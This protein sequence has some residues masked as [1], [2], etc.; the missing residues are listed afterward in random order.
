MA[1]NVLLPQWGMNMEDGLLVKWLVEEGDK[2]EKGQPLVEVETAKINSE[3]ES[4]NDGILS[5]IMENAGETVTVGTVIAIITEPGESLPRPEKTVSTN[6]KISRS[7]IATKETVQ[8]INRDVQITPVARRLARQYAVNLGTLKG[9]GPNGRITE[10]DV[11]N[12]ANSNQETSVEVVPA[13][14]K[15]AKENNISLTS[16]Q[17]S[18]PSGR[19]LLSDV[20]RSLELHTG[21]AEIVPLTGLR[22]VISERMVQSVQ[23]MAQVTLTTEVDVTEVVEFMEELIS[24]WRQHR[25]RPVYQD[26]VIKAVSQALMEH[27]RL[28]AILTDEGIRLINDV[29]I[30]VAM[31]VPSGLLVPVV[32]SVTEKDIL[33]IAKET[34]SLA[35]KCKK[36][37][38]GI[39]DM[40]DPSFTITSLSNYDID[41]FTPIINP[42]QVA[43][44]GLGRV[45]AKP[46][47]VR[48]EIEI[49]SMAFLS[50]TFDHRAI[51]G[52]PSGEFL[53]NLKGKLEDVSWM[54]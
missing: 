43:I 51:D 47:V 25:V 8:P 26:I 1:I 49:R 13:A 28:N 53:R 17:G 21:D 11:R 44:L 16:V 48:N 54:K 3:L 31:A 33:T 45:V 5:Y 12:A 42:P 18:G 40:T 35:K 27:P 52:V 10:E 23:T 6:K 15:L 24:E 22:K 4:P 39:N 19:V 38:L 14:R 29:N 36:E 30:G 50:L 2:V 32:K 9:T 41:A 37:Q 34:R 20:E 7:G 46:V